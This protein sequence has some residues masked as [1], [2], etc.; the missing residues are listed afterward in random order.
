MHENPF[1]L[2]ND[3]MCCPLLIQIYKTLMPLPL[4]QICKSLLPL[5]LLS[6]KRL[7]GYIETA[8]WNGR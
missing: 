2:L 3:G 8:E 7:K 1:Y 6:Y 5:S 4:V